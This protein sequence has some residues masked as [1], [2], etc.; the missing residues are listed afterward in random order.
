MRPVRSHVFRGKRWKVRYRKMADCHG[1]TDA[2]QEPGK[3][4]WLDPRTDGIEHLS[5]LLDEGIH[6]C[7]WDL[8][9]EIVAEI[10]TD[11]ARWLWRMGYR[12]NHTS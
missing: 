12:R 5:T 6:C 8:D 10:A 1:L 7:Q 4:I 11:L 9:N 3:E 2:P